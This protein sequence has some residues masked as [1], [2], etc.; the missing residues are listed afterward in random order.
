[1]KVYFSYAYT[2]PVQLSDAIKQALSDLV[3]SSN[4]LYYVK[5][6]EYTD[7]NI[8]NS[9]VFCIFL[10]NNSFE[11]EINK[12]SSGIQK[13]LLLAHKLGKTIILAYYSKLANGI[14]FYFVE[15]GA[16]KIKGIAGTNSDVINLLKKP[17]E[18]SMGTDDIPSEIDWLMTK[19]NIIL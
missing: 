2:T 16:G 17:S 15:L 12:M 7:R 18:I 5:G 8:V 1:M 10:P 19:H 3:G 4:V 13:E 9:D 11:L 14:T 6:T